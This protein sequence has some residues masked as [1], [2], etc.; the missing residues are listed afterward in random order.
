[1]EIWAIET[2]LTLTLFI[3]VSVPSQKMYL[4]VRD[5]DFASFYA[6]DI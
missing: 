2:N 6:F 1:V 4:C 5:I 3:E